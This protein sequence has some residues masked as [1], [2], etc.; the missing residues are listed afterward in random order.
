MRNAAGMLLLVFG[1]AGVA[2][3]SVGL[4][5]PEVDPGSAVSALTI[6]AGA[7]LVRRRNKA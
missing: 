2:S 5:A 3:A 1:V 4:V 7:L 6:L